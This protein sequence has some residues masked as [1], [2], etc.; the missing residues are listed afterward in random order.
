LQDILRNKIV[1]AYTLF[2]L[3]VSVSMFQLGGGAKGILSLLNVLLI[4]VPLVSVVFSTIPFYNSYEFIELLV[5]QPVSRSHIFLSQYIGLATALT[6]AIVVGFGLPMLLFDASLLGFTMLLAG[7][8]LTLVFVALAFLAAVWARDKARGIGFA[9]MLWF[10]FSLIYDG[11]VLLILFSFADYP[12]E[13]MMWLFTALN[14]VDLARVSILLQMDVAA[15]MG[16]TGAAFKAFFGSAFGIS[17]SI[18][19]MFIWIIAPLWLAL[20]IFR[21]KDL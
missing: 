11:L 1:L 10:Y 7:I 20:R 21:K 19:T 18:T 16:F 2:L 6:A 13:K 14:P 17:F 9:L 4:V 15:L 3:I 5:A 12:L 8:G